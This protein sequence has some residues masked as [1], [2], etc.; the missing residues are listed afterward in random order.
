MNHNTYKTLNNYDASNSYRGTTAV[1]GLKSKYAFFNS[2]TYKLEI[3]DANGP[4]GFTPNTTIGNWLNPGDKPVSPFTG[5]YYKFKIWR[6]LPP[7][8]T[9][10]I[11]EF[12]MNIV[13]VADPKAYNYWK[14]DKSVCYYSAGLGTNFSL[15]YGGQLGVNNDISLQILVADCCG[16]DVVTCVPP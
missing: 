15:K 10:P 14:I 5:T 12:E 9:N 2:T 8:D 4:P 3:I 16:T 7:G 13:D 11:G 6:T 1:Q